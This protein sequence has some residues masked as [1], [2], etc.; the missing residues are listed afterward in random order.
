MDPKVIPIQ[1]RIENYEK[2]LENLKYWKLIFQIYNELTNRKKH[3]S[4]ELEKIEHI[5]DKCVPIITSEINIDEIDN[6]SINILIKSLVSQNQEIAKGKK[7]L[8]ITGLE[9][10]VNAAIFWQHRIVDIIIYLNT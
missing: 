9:Y 1:E 4:D 6:G 5:L 3:L 7:T 2:R 8:L 10:L